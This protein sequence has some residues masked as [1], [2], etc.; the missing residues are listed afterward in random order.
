MKTYLSVFRYIL[1]LM[2]IPTCI[3]AEQTLPALIKEV[4]PSIVLINTYDSNGDKLGSGSGFFINKKGEIITN[5]HVISN[6]SSA[7]VKSF[8]GAMFEVKGVVAKDKKRDLAIIMIKSRGI[9]F[10]FLNLQVKIPEKGER[11][12]V[13]GNPFG[14]EFTVSDGLISAVR[15]LPD[16]GKVIQIS[17]PISPGSSGSPIINL[18][19][20]V[21]GIASFQITKGQNLNFSVS[22]VEIAKFLEVTKDEIAPLIPELNKGVS[23]DKAAQ[24]QIYV[25]ALDFIK[26]LT[27]IQKAQVSVISNEE[28]NFFMLW[29]DEE[30]LIAA[31]NRIQAWRNSN[32]ADIRRIS[33]DLT[34]A[35]QALISMNKEIK[36]LGYECFAIAD[37]DKK[38]IKDYCDIMYNAYFS[39]K[40]DKQLGAFYKLRDK[41]S[42][43]SKELPI[44]ITARG[45]AK[46]NDTFLEVS[47]DVKFMLS[48]KQLAE[49]YKY[50]REGR[51]EVSD[52]KNTSFGSI[53][54]AFRITGLLICY[55]LSSK[56]FPDQCSIEY[57]K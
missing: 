15:D 22:S 20:D 53:D 38:Y 7:I 46:G 1:M 8:N 39:R 11:I 24:E 31:I 23:I 12:F 5:W 21:I 51:K 13:V 57:D 30:K 18:E 16:I 49:I 27:Y 6:A 55:E 17:A 40:N 32:H 34:V 50:I 47:S 33:E 25:F 3:F 41:F 2:M 10:P 19:G 44:L 42:E 54:S 4:Q 37:S 14:L 45:I 56:T 29:I 9:D 28:A 43:L 48:N 52:I 36:E 35:I 26:S